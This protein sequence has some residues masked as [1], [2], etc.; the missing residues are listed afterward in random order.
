MSRSYAATRTGHTQERS[1]RALPGPQL[2]DA[3]SVA[4]NPSLELGDWDQDELPGDHDFELGLHLALEVVDADPQ[5][6]GGLAAR[7]RVARDRRERPGLGAGHQISLPKSRLRSTPRS[8]DSRRDMAWR[9]GRSSNARSPW[10]RSAL[11]R[12]T[13]SS[14]SWMAASSRTARLSRSG[15][16]RGPERHRC[17]AAHSWPWSCHTRSSSVGSPTGLP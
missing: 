7:E 2:D 14:S 3:V 4:L 12:S 15:S 6:G 10:A 13:W 1:S 11:R 9:S 8:S 16:Q 17:W 5:R